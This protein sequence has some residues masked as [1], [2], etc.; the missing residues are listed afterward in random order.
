MPEFNVQFPPRFTFMQGTQEEKEKQLEDYLVRFASD[1][2]QTILRLF[3][4]VTE[5]ADTPTDGHVAS[6]NEDGQIEDSGVTK[7]DIAAT[8]SFSDLFPDIGTGDGDK[9]VQV[10][11]AEDGYDYSHTVRGTKTFASIP[12][13]PASDPTT[14]NQAA[15]KAYVDGKFNTT[16]GHDH[17][18]SDSKSINLLNDVDTEVFNGTAPMGTMTDLD[19]SATVGAN[20]ALVVLAVFNNNNADTGLSYAFRTNG[21][22]RDY[23]PY[24]AAWHLT[25]ICVYPKKWGTTIVKTDASGIIEWM[26]Y[27][28]AQAGTL[29]RVLGYIKTS[30]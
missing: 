20:K 8:I 30:S 10:T 5:V 27:N 23:N 7:D 14:D 13:L 24:L 21:D 3:N 16:T 4:R 28:A 12:T 26:C 11:T 15:R 25:G 22:T 2:E 19:L 1:I 9:V 6:L 18:G 29:I 17:D